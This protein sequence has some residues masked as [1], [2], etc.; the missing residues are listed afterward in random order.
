MRGGPRF[1]HSEMHVMED[2]LGCLCSVWALG[3]GEEHLQIWNWITG[4]SLAV[5]LVHFL[6]LCSSLTPHE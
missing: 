1:S 3:E 2:K 4:E 5:S 6:N